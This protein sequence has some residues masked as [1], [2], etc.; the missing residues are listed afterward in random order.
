MLWLNFFFLSS[1]IC[2]LAQS[3]SVTELRA[4]SLRQR[5]L[6]YDNLIAPIRDSPDSPTGPTPK[7][8][9]GVRKNT[10]AFLQSGSNLTEGD[11]GKEDWPPKF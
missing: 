2:F 11:P 4:V 5:P 3:V 8:V 7:V 9:E 6:S 10:A 1:V